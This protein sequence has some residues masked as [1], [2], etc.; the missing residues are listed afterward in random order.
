MLPG[1]NEL[2]MEYMRTD[3][4]RFQTYGRIGRP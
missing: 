4:V 2:R 3:G 1:N